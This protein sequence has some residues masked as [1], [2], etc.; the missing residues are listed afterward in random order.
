MQ[1]R[2]FITR[3]A[4]FGLSLG[5]IGLSA[6]NSGTDSAAAGEEMAEGKMDDKPVAGGSEELWFKIS[7]AQW[8]LNKAIF[9]GDLDNLDFAAKARNDFGIGGIEYV[10]QFF[11]DKAE[12][13]AYLGQMKQRAM[14]HDVQSLLIMIDREGQLGDMDEAKRIAAVENH[15]KW[16]DAAKF[17]GCH[18]IRVNAATGGD[19][20]EGAKAA[21]DGLRRLAEYG[22][23]ENINVIVENHGGWSS[24]GKWLS[25]VI[26]N[27][28]MD[29][30]GTL[31]D[32][33]NFCIEGHPANGCA[34]EYDRYQGMQD[35]MPYAKA[36]SAKS[37][38]FNEEGDERVMDY[39]RILK[40]VKD[41][42][43]RGWIGIEYEGSELSADEGIRATQALLIKAGKM[44]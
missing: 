42:G 27:T 21:T 2:K 15:Y 17:L 6:C 19:R 14:D 36:V 23:K 28:E 5:L 37:N 25:Q 32:F 8:S 16:V 34:N 40:T 1:R 7:L 18:S 13:M 38:V 30:C 26:A 41:H 29:N 44:V 9:A 31:P 43:Y 22:A 12:D 11:K 4:Q 24:D 10:N 33:G 3:S 35:L 20:E 39:Q